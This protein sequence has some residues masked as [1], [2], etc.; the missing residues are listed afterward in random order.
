MVGGG[1]VGRGSVV[2]SIP[3]S[4]KSPGEGNGN[5]LQYLAGYSPWGRKESDMTEH[6]TSP[7]YRMYYI[8]QIYIQTEVRERESVCVC[9]CV[10][11]FS[12][13]NHK[14]CRAVR[15]PLFSQ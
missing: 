5:P 1:G 12:T 7:L 15:I 6:E 13:G 14:F 2:D 9:V 4:G 11:V 10:C 3:G 8:T